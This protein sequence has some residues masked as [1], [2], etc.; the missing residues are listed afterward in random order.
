M[1][2]CAACRR[3][4]TTASQPLRRFCPAPTRSLA[5][6]DDASP[7]FTA[8]AAACSAAARVCAHTP[9]SRSPPPF[10][11]LA[12]PPF[13]SPLVSLFRPR[14]HTFL[15]PHPLGVCCSA[16]AALSAG[17]TRAVRAC[18][19]TPAK[20]PPP[21]PQPTV[22]AQS[23]A[24]ATLSPLDVSDFCHF[25]CLVFSRKPLSFMSK[26]QRFNNTH[27]NVLGSRSLRAARLQCGKKKGIVA[28]PSK[29]APRCRT[30]G[31]HA[32]AAV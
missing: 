31:P 23:R 26:K 10:L 28:V 13:V 29:A 25:P 5:L 19:R 20:P 3:R 27:D 21:P 17:P 9:L 1:W 11:L 30:A 24:P 7:S 22:R 16:A 8:A 32:A 15:L 6:H 14:A 18:A 12:P 4:P 2:W